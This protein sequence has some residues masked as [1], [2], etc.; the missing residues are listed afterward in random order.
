MGREI[1]I[2]M[3]GLILIILVIQ[4]IYVHEALGSTINYLSTD[5]VYEPYD[6][7][8]TGVPGENYV[9][10]GNLKHYRIL[11]EMEDK[12]IEM[13][14]Y[15]DEEK[16]KLVDVYLTQFERDLTRFAKE[17]N[18]SDYID[19]AKGYNVEKRIYSMLIGIY[20]PNRS[21]VNLIRSRL[22]E[23]ENIL[24]RD[25]NLRFPYVF[26]RSLMTN[27]EIDK[28]LDLFLNVTHDP[29]FHEELMANMYKWL[30]I[31]Y[32]RVLGGIRVIV[33]N[34]DAGISEYESWFRI[35]RKYFPEHIPIVIVIFPN[36]CRD[37]PIIVPDIEY[38]DHVVRPR[39]RRIEY[40]DLIDIGVIFAVAIILIIFSTLFYRILRFDKPYKF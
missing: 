21:V 1:F 24:T 20:N 37:K 12:Y 36:E 32:G 10:F 8:I 40:T 33:A 22:E 28:Y 17:N 9:A 30:F 4:G 3:D 6:I 38:R 29:K 11:S 35:L 23:Y 19:V 18:L 14:Y 34:S 7:K 15:I 16:S 39:S 5:T 31:D 27:S 2:K 13:G 25:L 26:F